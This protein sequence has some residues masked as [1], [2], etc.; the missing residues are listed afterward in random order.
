[1]GA[2]A[3]RRRATCSV[4]SARGGRSAGALKSSR[5]VGWCCI[6]LRI[7]CRWRTFFTSERG[8]SSRWM[9]LRA[10]SSAGTSY[11]AA[12]SR[13]GGRS[14]WDARP[15]GE[16]WPLRADGRQLKPAPGAGSS[17]VAPLGRG[18]VHRTRD[19]LTICR[20]R[21]APGSPACGVAPKDSYLVDSASSHMLVS[22][23]KPCMS[24]YKHL[25]G[26]TANGSLNQLSFI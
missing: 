19:C 22:K 14:R 13:D 25:Y 2:V 11:V 5:L 15:I 17:R 20:L 3:V 7:A 23:I 8:V 16:G 9:A 4:L 18:A 6:A 1:M 21:A 12:R 10:R 24:K 26:E